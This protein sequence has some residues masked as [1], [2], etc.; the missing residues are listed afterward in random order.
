MSL[1]HRHIEVFRAV[2]TAGSLTDAAK[3]LF[4]SQPT[5]S[6]ELARMEQ[7]LGFALFDRVRGRLQPTARALMLFDEVQRAYSGLERIINTAASLRQFAEGHL[8]LICLPVFSH[9]VLPGACRRFLA[10][11]PGVSIAITPQESPLLEEW[12]S[13]QRHDLGL[14]EHNLAPPG[15]RLLPLLEEDEVCVLPD[16]H[17][18]LAKQVLHAADFADE[19][20]IS[21]APSD[22]YR[23]QL[24]EMFRQHS[25]NRRLVVET[26]SAVSIC[27]M[28]SQG[29]GV[30]I[31]N[32]LTA[33]ECQGNKLHI[34]KL[35]VSIPFRVSIV[36]PEHRPS[37]PLTERFINALRGEAED[38][39]HRLL[40]I[41]E[42]NS[43]D[44]FYAENTR[45]PKAH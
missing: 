6:R 8:S 35:A 1:S 30:A 44:N 39:R 25:I 3:L 42:K 36:L 24:D 17:P 23:L 43:D 16:G 10:Q 45:Q 14:T 19:A 18:L 20:F 11:H 26:H 7:L 40:K 21:L 13:A 22:P 34:R 2:M 27:A 38:I 33:L 12:L 32:P 15:T 41:I 4:T 37:T 9:S 28:V 31:V 5:I 29:L